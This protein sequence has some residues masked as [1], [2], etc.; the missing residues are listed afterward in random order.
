MA[1]PGCV[2][3]NSF[4]HHLAASDRARLEPHLEVM[5]VV[6]GTVLFDA[7]AAGE[8]IYFPQG[9]LV[10]VEQGS[11]VEVAVIAN[12]GLVGWP[13]L[14]GLQESPFRAVVRGRD[15]LLLRLSTDVA[16]KAMLCSPAIGIAINSFAAAI[17]VQ[18]AETIGAFASHRIEVRLARWILLR[19]DRVGGDEIIAQHDEI[20]DNL[21]ARRASITDC[22]H[23]IEGAGSLRCR[24]GRISVRDR[25]ALELLAAGCYGEAESVYRQLIGAFGRRPLAAAAAGHALI[26]F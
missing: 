14:A 4:L 21:G 17:G 5:P 23:I 24:R 1:Q 22:L 25:A 3:P 2:L 10:S 12:E 13:A 7:A 16:R 6:R 15:G 8:H 11:R 26:R 20:A 19:H 9:P 18:M